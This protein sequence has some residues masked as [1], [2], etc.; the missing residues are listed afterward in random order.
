[1]MVQAMG[2][3]DVVQPEPRET[4]HNLIEGYMLVENPIPFTLMV[5]VHILFKMTPSQLKGFDDAFL[6]AQLLV[7]QSRVDVHKVII[8]TDRNDPKSDRVV[9]YDLD[10]DSCNLDAFLDASQTITS[11]QYFDSMWKQAG[12]KCRDENELGC[13]VKPFESH[14]CLC[15]K[16]TKA[17][18]QKLILLRCR[19]CRK[20][21]IQL[22][23][24]AA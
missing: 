11:H 17:W 2:V 6:A 18:S 14:G 23:E 19:V 3:P 8:Q 4:A 15:R 10:M 7:G 9:Q 20:A 21:P 5:T 12:P 16:H 1:M 22:K 13:H 24:E